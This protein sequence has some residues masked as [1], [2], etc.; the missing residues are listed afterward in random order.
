MTILILSSF[1]LWLCVIF[2]LILTFALVRRMNIAF[3]TDTEDMMQTGEAIPPFEAETLTGQ[4]ASRDDYIG[5]EITMVFVSANCGPCKEQMPNL[6][7]WYPLAKQAGMELLIVSTSDPRSTTELVEELGGFEYPILI[8]PE[9][10]TSIK[11]DYK[12][13]ATPSYYIIDASGKVKAG[14]LCA[15]MGETTSV[16]SLV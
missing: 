4:I 15:R 13:T 14:A 7:K 5:R 3:S 11:A 16:S 6:R 12:I 1:L 10:I 2:N 8:A 9:G